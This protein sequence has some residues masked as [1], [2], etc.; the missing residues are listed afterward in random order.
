MKFYFGKEFGFLVFFY[1]GG[2]MREK[3]D[4]DERRLGEGE[5]EREREREIKGHS[6]FFFYFSEKWS[7]IRIKVEEDCIWVYHSNL[8]IQ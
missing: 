7:T 1:S 4:K 3:K 5:R 6:D 8:L 2:G